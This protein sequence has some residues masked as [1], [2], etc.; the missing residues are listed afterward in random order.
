MENP[1][2]QRAGLLLA[3]LVFCLSFFSVEST[4][5]TIQ[6]YTEKERQALNQVRKYIYKLLM[7]LIL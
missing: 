6:I 2:F 3:A 7:D 5:Q 1:R 4:N